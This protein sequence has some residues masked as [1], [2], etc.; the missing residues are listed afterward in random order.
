MVDQAHE[1]QTQ[2]S[3]EEVSYATIPVTY[4]NYLYSV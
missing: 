1:Q 3:C 2:Y 4:L